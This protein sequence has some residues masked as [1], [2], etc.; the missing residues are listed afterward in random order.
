[1]MKDNDFKLLGVL[2]LDR[3]TDERTDI[4][5]CRV[6]FAT[7]NYLWKHFL[8]H[9]RKIHNKIMNISMDR[10]TGII[11]IIDIVIKMIIDI[12]RSS[13][14]P[15]WS[16]SWTSS[17]FQEENQMTRHFTTRYFLHTVSLALYRIHRHLVLYSS[18]K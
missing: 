4:Y 10:I 7:E 5:D 18:N 6:A 2:L 12:I 14:T 9:Q 11:D 1:M 3:Q 17:R 13:W 16:L 15:S 8:W